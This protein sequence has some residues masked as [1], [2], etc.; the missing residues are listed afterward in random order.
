MG[1]VSKIKSKL[2]GGGANTGG[3]ANAGGTAVHWHGGGGGN[4]PSNITVGGR[5][6][7]APPAIQSGP[8]NITVGGRQYSHNQPQALPTGI[9]GPKKSRIRVA[10][11]TIDPYVNAATGGRKKGPGIT[12]S[13]NSYQ[14]WG[15]RGEAVGRISKNIA[16][17]ALDKQKFGRRVAKAERGM[18]ALSSDLRGFSSPYG[19]ATKGLGMPRTRGGRSRRTMGRRR[20][21]GSDDPFK[22]L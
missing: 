20:S 19:F 15:E 10:L 18:G 1:I 14:S 17:S 12:R 4:Q 7:N 3:N 8:T 13:T 21:Y 11:N 9:Q 6:Y 22:F 5:Q 2:T 16:M